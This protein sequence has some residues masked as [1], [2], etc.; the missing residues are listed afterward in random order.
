MTTIHSNPLFL[1]LLLSAGVYAPTLHAADVAITLPP[2]G[3]FVLKDSGSVERFKV[4]GN[5]EVQAPGL[6]TVAGT[7]ACIEGPLAA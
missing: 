7:P 5:G 6:P 4:L 2:G 1:A 3:N